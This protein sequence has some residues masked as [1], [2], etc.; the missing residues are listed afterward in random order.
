MTDM[1]GNPRLVGT[2]VDIGAY[3]FQG[4]E[5]TIDAILLFFDQSVAD[6]TLEG[7]GK[8][9][10]LAKL[11]LHHMRK[12]LETVKELIE[13]DKIG[14]ACH[15]LKLSY[16]R[17]DGKIIPFDYVTGDAVTELNDMISELMAELGCD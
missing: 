8:N 11:R 17:C 2:N 16:L 13:Q 5:N 12:M 1:D 3:E 10:W 6:G 7:V 14:W 9:P 15:I 4:E